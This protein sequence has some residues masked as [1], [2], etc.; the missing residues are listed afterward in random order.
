VV[1]SAASLVDVAAER[2]R[3]L[4][5]DESNEWLFVQD[6]ALVFVWDGTPPDDA[7]PPADR[8]EAG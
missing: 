6:D 8:E 5:R 7:S 3:P 1:D 4:H 2:G